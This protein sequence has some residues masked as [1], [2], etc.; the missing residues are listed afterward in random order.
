MITSKREI[1]VENARKKEYSTIA[2]R[3]HGDE[4][5]LKKNSQNRHRMGLKNIVMDSLMSI[6][7][8]IHSY[9]KRSWK[10]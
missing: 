3:W 6:D 4:F 9:K 5:F 1:Q 7:F 8:L 10:I 2:A